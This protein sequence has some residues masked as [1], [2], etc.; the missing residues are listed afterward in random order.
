MSSWFSAIFEQVQLFLYCCLICSKVSLSIWFSIISILL[1]F[2]IYL[3]RQT[4]NSLVIELAISP[5][6]SAL[7]ELSTSCEHLITMSVAFFIWIIVLSISSFLSVFS[8]LMHSFN[9]STFSFSFLA[10][11]YFAQ[12]KSLYKFSLT[13]GD[14]S[15][16]SSIS[17]F[18]AARIFSSFDFLL[19]PASKLMEKLMSSSYLMYFLHL[20]TTDLTI[21]VIESFKEGSTLTIFKLFIAQRCINFSLDSL[22]IRLVRVDLLSSEAI[23]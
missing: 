22:A 4:K 10:M 14:R 21:L 5:L 17:F 8:P 20:V 2:C 23:S 18:L 6:F 7:S 15:M 9:M 1:I 19:S 16:R 11:F 13:I 12:L 3:L